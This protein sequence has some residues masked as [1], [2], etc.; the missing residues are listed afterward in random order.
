VFS[1]WQLHQRFLLLSPKPIPNRNR[2]QRRRLAM[3]RHSHPMRLLLTIGT[4]AVIV[5]ATAVI[6]VLRAST[7]RSSQKGGA[8]RLPLF[9][10]LLCR[11]RSALT[12]RMFQERRAPQ[13]RC[14]QLWFSSKPGGVMSP[15]E[16]LELSS[17]MYS[18]AA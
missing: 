18:L 3:A 11:L 2:F 1:C 4:I 17:P 8:G 7:D 9:A 10:N 13:E 5:A 14:V 15:P 16:L 6:T 12:K